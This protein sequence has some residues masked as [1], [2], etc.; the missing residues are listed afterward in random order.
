MPINYIFSVSS[1]N[2]LTLISIIIILIIVIVIAPF[3][4]I[5]VIMFCSYLG[6][7]TGQSFLRGDDVQRVICRATTLL[8]GC[9]S[10][11]LTVRLNVM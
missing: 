5:I 8:M 6:H 2:A 3:L 1:G 9:S 4:N 11:K 10:A 7:G